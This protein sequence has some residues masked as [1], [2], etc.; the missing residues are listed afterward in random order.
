MTNFPKEILSPERGG[1]VGGR[2]LLG[3]NDRSQPFKQ[4]IFYRR[5]L[6]W[7]IS[8]SHVHFHGHPPVLLFNLG[9]SLAPPFFLSQAP[10]HFL[11]SLAIF[12][13]RIALLSTL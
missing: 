4:T 7:H 9:P 8:P 2:K 5:N 13:T 11:K 12:S 10:P 6:Y 3:H 1:V